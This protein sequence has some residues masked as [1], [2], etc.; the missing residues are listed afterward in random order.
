VIVDPLQRFFRFKDINDYSE[1]SRGF[2]IPTE[3]ARLYGCHVTFLHHMGKEE[4]AGSPSDG[5]LGSTALFANVDLALLMRKT[6]DVRTIQTD[7]PQRYG[8]DLPP[9]VLRYNPET[10][11]ITMGDELAAAKRE[12]LRQHIMD[13][14]GSLVL[15]LTDLKKAIG[16]DSARAHSEIIS[17]HTDGFLERTGTGV[18]GD[19][20]YFSV[21]KPP[22]DV[23]S[24]GHYST[25]DQVQQRQ[26]IT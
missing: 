25:A 4:H 5:I 9:T 13:A 17:M 19:P 10:G 12:E 11:M 3:I 21:R 24:N 1:V 14:L 22:E 8:I 26:R 20:Y 23:R 18:R 6:E 16:G 2:E 15:P 7:G